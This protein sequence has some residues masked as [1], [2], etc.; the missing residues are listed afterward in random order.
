MSALFRD[1]HHALR[2]LLR[3]PG[4]A[5][6]IV[7]TLAVGIGANSAIFTY[8]IEMHRARFEAPE[9]ERLFY[10]RGGNDRGE[11]DL[12]CSM[13]DLLDIRDG[14]EGLAEMRSWGVLGM[15]AVLPGGES[16]YTFA[17]AIEPGYFDLYA[18]R[19]HR[20]RFFLPEENT[21]GGER[22]VVVDYGFWTRRLGG[23]PEIVG[24]TLRLGRQP[25]TVVGIAPRGFQGTGFT[26]P[27]F[28]PAVRARRS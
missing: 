20:G 23:D 1:L 27:L 18:R 9:P 15:V 16:I 11:D 19:P 10:L 14:L 3:R 6:V 28:V 8:L 2:S 25:Y 24:K 21:P 13:P 22:A 4:L 26:W 17:S 12:P 7:S 5:L